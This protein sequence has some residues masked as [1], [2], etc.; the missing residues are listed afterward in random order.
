[1]PH[2]VWK[3]FLQLSL[4]SLPVRAYSATAAAEDIRLNQLHAGCGQRIR[5]RKTCP[6]HGEVEAD[7]ITSAYEY[8]TGQFVVIDDDELD[9]LYS[10]TE[11]AVTIDGFVDPGEIDQ[12]YLTGRTYYLVP[13]GK[14]GEKAYSLLV[15][16][17]KDERR[18]AVAKVAMHG[19][20]HVVLLRPVG[21]LLA[22]QFLHFSSQVREPEYVERE[23]SAKLLDAKRTKRLDCSAYRDHYKDDL[24]RLI[25]AKVAGQQIVASWPPSRRRW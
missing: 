5:Y 11:R 25:E 14:V 7:Q 3:G 13:D 17:M 6:L 12:R 8:A 23:L 10:P 2:A 16:G 15:R 19:R 1:M 21:R 20:E 9:R 22:M 4:V 24:R 18:W